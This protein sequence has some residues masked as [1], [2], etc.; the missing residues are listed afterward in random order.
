MLPQ[1]KKQTSKPPR[2]T[3]VFSNFLQ[4]R[5]SSGQERMVQKVTRATWKRYLAGEE[6][7][8]VLAT[9]G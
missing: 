9:P 7:C 5:L 4:S 1:R 2:S 8:G 6:D 3:S